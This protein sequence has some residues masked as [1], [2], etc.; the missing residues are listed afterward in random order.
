MN[1][2][3]SSVVLLVAVLFLAFSCSQEKKAKYVFYFIGDGMGFSHISLTEGY[4]AT[5][6]GKIGNNP[7]CF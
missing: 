7:L 6:E 1:K 4:L 2:R 3:F 5:K